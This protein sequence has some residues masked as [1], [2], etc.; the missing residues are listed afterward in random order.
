[1]EPAPTALVAQRLNPWTAREVPGVL[2]LFFFLEYFKGP[3]MSAGLT[4]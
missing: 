1:M 3:K 2:Y 4:D